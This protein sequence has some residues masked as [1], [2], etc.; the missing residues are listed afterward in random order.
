M[1]SDGKTWIVGE[2][3]MRV[4]KSKASNDRDADTARNGTGR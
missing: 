2:G 4:V 1:I 3:K